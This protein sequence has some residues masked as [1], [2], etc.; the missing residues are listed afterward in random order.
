MS[1][2][3]LYIASILL[4]I[5]VAIILYWLYCCECGGKSSNK[6]TDAANNLIVPEETTAELATPLP[7]ASSMKNWQ[8]IREKLNANPLICYFPISESKT[9]LN[10][11]EIEK[12][13]EIIEY[14]QNNPDERLLVTGH[15]DNTGSRDLNVRLS[16]NRADFVKSYLVRNGTDEVQ[17]TSASKGP[18]DPV[19][20]NNTSEGRLKNRRAVILI[21]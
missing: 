3:F 17:I 11:N 13:K 9:I 18:D 19:A 21:K 12:L 1:R 8:A 4:T 15:S 20:D 16:Q 10:Q 6:G 14:L 7:D 2:K 5:I